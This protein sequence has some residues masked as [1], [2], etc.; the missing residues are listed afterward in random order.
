MILIAVTPWVMTQP[1]KILLHVEK[2]IMIVN[3]YVNDRKNV[4]T[5]KD[6]MGK[7]V[8]TQPKGAG[9][10]PRNTAQIHF[11]DS[12]KWSWMALWF[13]QLLKSILLLEECCSCLLQFDMG[14]TVC[15]WTI[16]RARAFVFTFFLGRFLSGKTWSTFGSMFAYTGGYVRLISCLSAY[17]LLLSWHI[18]MFHFPNHCYVLEK[19]TFDALRQ[20]FV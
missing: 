10:V 4:L 13:V 17:R 19:F 12:L 15:S 16:H 14:I 11:L 6:I 3:T 8:S 1:W 9:R 20:N 18:H 5:R 2:K 7:T